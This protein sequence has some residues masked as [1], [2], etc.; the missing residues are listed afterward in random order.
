[1]GCAKEPRRT[2]A[3]RTVVNTNG[4][5]SRSP[6][7]LSVYRPA[8]STWRHGMDT[9]VG[10][11]TTAEP[12]AG[13]GSLGGVFY[14]HVG[15]DNLKLDTTELKS[16]GP[17]AVSA[18][19]RDGVSCRHVSVDKRDGAELKSNEP[20]AASIGLLGGVSCGRVGVGVLVWGGAGLK[21][22]DAEAACA[23]SHGGESCKH[24]GVDKRDGAKLKSDEL[25]TDPGGRNGWESKLDLTSK[26]AW[27]SL[28]SLWVA[29]GPAAE[30]A[31]TVASRVSGG[32][33]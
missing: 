12:G 13:A 5:Q 21:P 31:A 11:G 2:A 27:F 30:A 32:S 24:V 7:S 1:M 10:G 3:V 8:A 14:K 25:D 17:G 28:V 26:V 33:I 29:D 16:D 9:G 19:S 23:C 18:C 15:V 20:R 6:S 4:V 22:D